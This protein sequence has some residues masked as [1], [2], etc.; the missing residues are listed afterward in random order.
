MTEPRQHTTDPD[1]SHGLLVSLLHSLGGAAEIRREDYEQGCTNA[2]GEWNSVA[3]EPLD[4]T[5]RVR[6]VLIARAS[7]G[8]RT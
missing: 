4:D 1:L 2:R 7:G 5:G 8:D 3:V 6:L